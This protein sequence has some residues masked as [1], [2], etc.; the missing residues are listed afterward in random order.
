[1][2]NVLKMLGALAV[3]GSLTSCFIT[4]G[5]TLTAIQTS[6]LGVDT[7][8]VKVFYKVTGTSGSRY[9]VNPNFVTAEA[10]DSAIVV[11]NDPAN[12]RAVV[13]VNNT[14][15]KCAAVAFDEG[16]FQIVTDK[17][18]AISISGIISF[19]LNGTPLTLNYN[20]SFAKPP[21]PASV[22]LSVTEGVD[23]T[24]FKLRFTA[25]DASSA[26]YLVNK[27]GIAEETLV[28]IT[29]NGA[30]VVSPRAVGVN[31]VVTC[32]P[33]PANVG[34]GCFQVTLGN[35]PT[36]TKTVA[37]SVSFKLDGVLLSLPFTHV[38][39]TVAP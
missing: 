13:V 2:K 28:N 7:K 27:A 3:A 5:D 11:S 15:T 10:L 18:P 34:E 36:G 14:L 6:Q 9:D 22:T 37:G 31:S 33:L 12:P 19:K 26:A 17:S 38:F 24:S 32:D 23:N 39:P 21:V 30:G 35:R 1:M 25:K 4:F 16:C 29:Q 20:A 8:T